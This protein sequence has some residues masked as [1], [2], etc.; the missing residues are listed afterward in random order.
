MIKGLD[1][2]YQ[3]YTPAKVNLRLFVKR[4]R[5]DGYHELELDLCPIS[6]FDQLTINPNPAGGFLLEADPSLG[7]PENN[8]ISRAVR[9]LERTSGHQLELKISLSKQVPHGAGLGGG[10]ANAAGVL[11]YLNQLFGLG[12]SLDQLHPLALRLGTDVPFFLN[13]RPMIGRGL[14]DQLTP[15]MGLPPLYLLL[16]KPSL[17]ISTAEAYAQVK[18]SGRILTTELYNTSL[19]PIDPEENDFFGPLAERFPILEKLAAL[20]KTTSP[21]GIQLSG[22]GSTMFGIYTSAEARDRAA[23]SLEGNKLA[24]LFPA[25]VLQGFEYGQSPPA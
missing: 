1:Q 17:F 23:A 18:P 20:L 14:G 24:N 11:V 2:S 12:L 22:S 21:Q 6:L 5:P 4:K 8:L 10:S 19:F 15:L 7:L 9:A 25:R 13:P 16:L 3:L